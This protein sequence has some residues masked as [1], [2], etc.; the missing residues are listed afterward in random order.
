MYR[1]K[2]SVSARPV[3]DGINGILRRAP[4]AA[5]ASRQSSTR[6]PRARSGPRPRTRP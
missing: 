2:L 1:L 3:L 6:A 4:S 5:C